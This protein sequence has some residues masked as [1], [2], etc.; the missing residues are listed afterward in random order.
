MTWQ[1]VYNYNGQK[2]GGRDVIQTYDGG[3]IICGAL[4]NKIYLI[5]LNYLGVQEWDKVLADTLGEYLFAFAIQQTADSGYIMTGRSGINLAIIKTDKNGILEWKKKYSNFAE[6]SLGESIIITSDN[7]YL[8]CGE[9]VTN[10]ISFSYLVKTDNMGNLQWE[11]MYLDSGSTASIA[12]DILEFSN[13]YYMSGIST[14][15]KGY[16]RKLDLTGKQIWQ[17]NFPSIVFFPKILKLLSNK[18]IFAGLGRPYGISFA[19]ID[20]SGKIL[21]NKVTLTSSF[22]FYFS[23]MC[24]NSKQEIVVCGSQRYPPKVGFTYFAAAVLDTNGNLLNENRLNSPNNVYNAPYA[25]QSTLDNGYIFAGDTEYNPDSDNLNPNNILVAKTDSNFNTP[26]VV[27]IENSSFYIENDYKLFQNYP[28]PFN[29][30]TNIGFEII[31]PGL[32]E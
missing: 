14:T 7:G 6:Y 28:N 22:E 8:A 26:Q 16:L 27:N 2:S 3:Y 20:T 18:I 24:I 32:V 1:N 13:Y 4:P 21:I 11:R 31:K 5:K 23:S 9:I 17:L 30:T 15:T 29:P 25:I 19:K 10:S 12:S